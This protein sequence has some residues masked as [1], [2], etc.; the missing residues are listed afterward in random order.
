LAI[1]AAVKP[2]VR[3]G[4]RS[5][6]VLSACVLRRAPRDVG[7]AAGAGHQAHADFHQADVAFHRGDAALRVHGQLAAAAQR[8]AADGGHHRHAGI[9]Q[10]QHGLLHEAFGIL[11]RADAHGHEGRQQRLQVGAHLNGSS[12]DQITRPTKSFSASV[13]RLLQA[14]AHLGADGVHLGLE[15]GDQHLLVQRPQADGLVLVQR[16][17]RRLEAAALRCPARPRGTAGA[18]ARAARGAARTARRRIPRSL[19]VCTPPASATG[20]LNTQSGSGA[21]DSALPAS[22]SSWIHCATCSQPASCHS[23]NGPCFMPKPQRMAKS[24]SRAVSAIDA[25]C[26]AA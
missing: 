4:S 11:D 1:A 19:G 7:Q 6:C 14:F 16:A 17:C 22:M 21:V 5:L 10:L 20:P 3:K 2:S 23:S 26:T 25:R 13:D 24:T 18:G 15:A 8:H 12:P 9:A